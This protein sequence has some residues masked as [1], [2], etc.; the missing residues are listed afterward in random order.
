MERFVVRL[1][2]IKGCTEGEVSRAPP[3]NVASTPLHRE[4]HRCGEDEQGQQTAKNPMCKWALHE[5][6]DTI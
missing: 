3:A 2:R 5:C 6:K 1:A 4:P